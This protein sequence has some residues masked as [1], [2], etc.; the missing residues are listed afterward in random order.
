MK[1]YFYFLCFFVYFFLFPAIAAGATPS[2]VP[3]ETV[4]PPESMGDDLYAFQVRLGDQVLTLPASFAGMEAAGWSFQGDAGQRLQP[5]ESIHT[6]TWEKEGSVLSASF[7]NLGM[8]TLRLENCPMVALSIANYQLKQ[9]AVSLPADIVLGESL[10]EDV[11]AA[12]GEPT[13]ELESVGVLTYRYWLT[14]AQFVS[15]RF[16]ENQEFRLSA[17]GLHNAAQTLD[18]PMPEPTEEAGL[19]AAEYQAPEALGDDPLAFIC[20][21]GGQ[22]YGIPAPFAAFQ[23]DGWTL[24]RPGTFIPARGSLRVDLEKDGQ[25]LRTTLINPS[26]KA[27]PS[28]QGWV[29]EVAEGRDIQIAL[30]LPRGVQRGISE[31]ELLTAFADLPL[32]SAEENDDSILYTFGTG[33]HSCIRVYV[34][35]KKHTVRRIELINGQ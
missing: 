30:E 10:P 34:G 21:Y 18:R 5:Q 12:Y 11:R 14:S 3:A 8:D 25:Y 24:E 9:L 17:I 29:T 6:A 4:I 20:H 33:I 32:L 22:I 7:A 27:V 23:E 28:T 19:D 31:E 2:P 13:D 16:D 15:L 1:T 35:T 26:D